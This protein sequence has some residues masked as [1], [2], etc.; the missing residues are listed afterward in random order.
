MDAKC[1]E[2]AEPKHSTQAGESAKNRQNPSHN[3]SRRIRRALATTQAEESAETQRNPSTQPEPETRRRI[4]RM[5]GFQ[6]NSSFFNE[7]L[8]HPRRK[9]KLKFKQ[10]AYRRWM[11]RLV[12]ETIRN[13]SVEFR[14][15]IRIQLCNR[16]RILP[17]NSCKESRRSQSR[18]ILRFGFQ[19]AFRFVCDSMKA[20]FELRRCFTCG[21]LQI[22]FRFVAIRFCNGLQR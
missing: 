13:G 5:H 16:R 17:K 3:L 1:E 22:G 21:S 7:R 15:S 18:R 19:L 2:S 4:Q 6:N 11:E 12:S 8:A 9:W 14:G 20:L 10:D